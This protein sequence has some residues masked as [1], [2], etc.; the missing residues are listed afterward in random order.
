MRLTLF[1]PLSPTGTVDVPQI[2]PLCTHIAQK[3]M[4]KIRQKNGAYQRKATPL[5]LYPRLERQLTGQV[6]R[7]GPPQEGDPSAARGALGARDTH[8]I[9]G[10]LGTH[11]THNTLGTHGTHTIHGTQ[12][13]LSNPPLL[14]A[15]QAEQ[16]SPRDPKNARSEPS[17][18]A[19]NLG[20]SSFS[21]HPRSENTIPLLTSQNEEQE[22]FQPRATL[23]DEPKS[24]SQLNSAEE[25]NLLSTIKASPQTLLDNYKKTQRNVSNFTD[26][27]QDS[28]VLTTRQFDLST[29]HLESLNEPAE[30]MSF[31]L[32]Q[33]NDDSQSREPIT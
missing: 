25:E 27:Y 22:S 10:T 5:H 9:H 18:V 8:S 21:V 4:T 28:Q 26:K 29:Q 24:D 12:D 15:S 2:Q 32:S 13:G 11:N 14:L 31:S 7:Y 3:F 17:E 23:D 16:P 30:D 1:F 33:L 6:P 19:S 20:N